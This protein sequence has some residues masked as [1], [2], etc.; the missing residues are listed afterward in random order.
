MPEQKTFTHASLEEVRSEEVQELMGKMPP[1]IVRSGITM[2]GIV[3]L[4]TLVMAACLRFPEVVAVRVS[5]RGSEVQAVVPSKDVWKVRPGQ[6]VVI[7]LDAYPYEQYG[8]LQGMVQTIPFAI[9]DTTF[10][11]R[12]K[13]KQGRTTA[14][15]KVIPLQPLLVADAEIVISEKSLLYRLSRHFLTSN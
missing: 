4:C 14:T 1:W 13:L 10:T 7:R 8:V 3:L 9:S 5:V 6:A 2:I 12:I 15:G 11:C